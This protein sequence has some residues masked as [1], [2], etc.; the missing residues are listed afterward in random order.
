MICCVKR[1]PLHNG[2][3]ETRFL[4]RLSRRPLGLESKGRNWEI[5]AFAENLSDEEYFVYNDNDIAATLGKR[6]TLGLNLKARF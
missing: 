2:H 5:K 3:E 4:P 1:P 6:R